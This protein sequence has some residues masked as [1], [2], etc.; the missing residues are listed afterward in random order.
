M[1]VIIICRQARGAGDDMLTKRSNSFNSQFPYS[2]CQARITWVE[3]GLKTS[4]DFGLLS[5]LIICRNAV[6]VKL[7]DTTSRAQKGF[8][9][10]QRLEMLAKGLNPNRS[11]DC[12][13]PEIPEITLSHAKRRSVTNKRTNHIVV[14]Q[15]RHP[16]RSHAIPTYGKDTCRDGSTCDTS[17]PTQCMW[18]LYAL[19]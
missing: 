10:R 16:A 3:K 15:A 2:P 17:Q 7:K 19:Q 8:F 6:R 18:T 5:I 11:S 1:N 14:N 13:L 9:R 4:F 12:G